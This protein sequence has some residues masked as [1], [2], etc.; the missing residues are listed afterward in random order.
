MRWVGIA[1][2]VVVGGAFVTSGCAK[3]AGTSDL[4]NVTSTDPSQPMSGRTP[5]Y[6]RFRLTR[7][8]SETSTGTKFAAFAGDTRVPELNISDAPFAAVWGGRR[9]DTG[10]FAK[11]KTPSNE[12]FGKLAQG[13]SIEGCTPFI[14]PRGAAAPTRIQWTPYD[15][16]VVATWE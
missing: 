6:V 1:V 7:T 11:C 9:P 3:D 12:D 10:I 8:S 16:K 4:D 15:G 13:Q 5:Y 14:T 2:A